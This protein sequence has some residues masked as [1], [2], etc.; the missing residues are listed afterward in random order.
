MKRF[1][2]TALLLSMGCSAVFASGKSE[3]KSSAAEAAQQ[4]KILKVMSKVAVTTMDNDVTASGGDFEVISNFMDG[5]KQLA[6]DGTVT[7]ALCKSET[8]SEDG[9]TRTYTLRD[10]AVWSNGTPV[11]AHDFVFGWRRAVDPE[12]ASEYSYFMYEVGHVKNAEAISMGDLPLTDLGVKALDDYTFEVTLDTPIPYFDDILITPLF[13]PVNEAF[14]DSCQGA[15]A[16]SPDTMLSNGA[17]IVTDY[18]PAAVMFSM[19][20]NPTYYDADRIKIDGL[21]FQ[22]M[23]DSQQALMSYEN[24]DLDV[25]YVGGDQIDQVSGDPEFSTVPNGYLWYVLPN[26]DKVE[27]LKNKN[28]RLA[29]SYALNRDEIVNSVVKDGSIPTYS[30]VPRGMAFDENGN[31]FTAEENE[32]SDVCEYNTEKAAVYFSKALS[33]LGVDAIDLELTCDDPSVQQN[34]AVVIKE[35]LEKALPGLHISLKVVPTK[36][37]ITNAINGD[38][39][40]VLERWG[41]SFTDPTNYLNIWTTGNMIN[42]GKWSNADYDA[43]LDEAITG[44]LATQPAKRW[45]ALKKAESIAMHEAMVFPL[46]VGANALMVQP[47]VKNLEVHSVG[48]TRVFKDVVIQ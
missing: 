44:S 3:E 36:Q 12:T 43:L 2:I 24:G 35:Q 15:Y 37:R 5:L 47:N 20:K 28:L 7:N 45:V 22:V 26:W 27:K 25:A 42:D 34:T 23:L 31:D 17:F 11:T 29:L 4:P 40:L 9:L 6:P 39:E 30:L 10:D 18:Q 19:K 46:Y 16:T 48:I 13:F 41:V 38:F 21:Q 8:I 1:L 14:Y 32:Y 33:E